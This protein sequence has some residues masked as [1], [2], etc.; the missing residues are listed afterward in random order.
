MVI[1]ISIIRYLHL[2]LYSFKSSF[3]PLKCSFN[4]LTMLPYRKAFESI[5]KSTQCQ[6]AERLPPFR[7]TLAVL[8][9]STSC[10]QLP[11]QACFPTCLC[12]MTSSW[13]YLW[14]DHYAKSRSERNI[15]TCTEASRVLLL[16]G[17]GFQITSTKDSIATGQFVRRDRTAIFSHEAIIRGVQRHVSLWL[18]KMIRF[19]AHEHSASF[20]TSPLVSPTYHTTH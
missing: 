12:L 1:D 17:T 8:L 6:K 19:H 15:S 16:H 3:R 13:K 11:Y 9:A 2:P 4:R 20:V 14:W 5:T 7:I 18:D 10:W